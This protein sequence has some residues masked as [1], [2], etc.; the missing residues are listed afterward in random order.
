MAKIPN[1][2]PITDLRQDATSIVKRVTSSRDPLI[3]TQRGRAAAVMVSMETY[4]HT[5]H[6]LEI[7]RLLASGE[8][9]IEA[10]KGYD[11]DVVLAEADS[12]L[13]GMKH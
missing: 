5:Q 8:K 11:L 1:I 7:L 6:E 4:E 2:V 3:I 12:L 10:G 9:E 13:E